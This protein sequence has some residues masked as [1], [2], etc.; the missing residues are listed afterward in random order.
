VEGSCENGN[1]PSGSIKFWEIV[2]GCTI[3]RF[4]RRAQL[5]EG[6]LKQALSSMMY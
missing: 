3:G 4:S 1:E 5:H 6:I 2:S